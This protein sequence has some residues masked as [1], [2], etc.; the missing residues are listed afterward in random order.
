M[1]YNDKLLKSFDYDL[2]SVVLANPHT[3][4]SHGSV[5]RSIDQVQPLLRHH[6]L[7][8]DFEAYVTN[9]IDGMNA[10]LECY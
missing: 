6:L 1:E 5:L 9:E 10:M 8:N 4:I 3:T 7:W 2:E